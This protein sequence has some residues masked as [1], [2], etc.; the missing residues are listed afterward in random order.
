MFQPDISALNAEHPEN[1]ALK[2]V[3]LNTS[4]REKFPLKT[5]R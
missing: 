4:Y 2:E 5:L 3:A 1:M